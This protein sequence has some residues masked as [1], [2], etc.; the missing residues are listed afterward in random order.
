LKGG[1]FES[2]SLSCSCSLS[3]PW[4]SAKVPVAIFTSVLP[5]RPAF[6]QQCS[7]LDNED[8]DENENDLGSETRARPIRVRCHHAHQAQAQSMIITCPS[9][10]ARSR[11]RARYRFPGC[12]QKHPALSS[13]LYSLS[14]PLLISHGQSSITRTTTRTSTI[15]VWV[16]G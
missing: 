16:A 12:Q 3:I 7:E 2:C 9:N 6:D 11:A 5:P 15:G 8:D 14:D 10:R 1:I 13:R 4:M